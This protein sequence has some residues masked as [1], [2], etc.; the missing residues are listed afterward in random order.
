MMRAAA[1]LF[2]YSALAVSAASAQTVDKPISQMP[3]SARQLIEIK[4]TGSQRFPEADIVA[5]CGLQ[6][7]KSVGEDDF[8]RAARQLADT[9]VFGDV[10]YKYSYSASGTKVEFQVTDA[11]KFVPARFLDFVW[12]P[13]AQMRKKIKEYV[14]LFE[15]QLPLSGNM[16]NQVS[17]VLQAMLVEHAIPGHVDY[18]RGGKDNGPVESIDYKVT[19]VLIRIRKID[20]T[21]AAQPELAELESAGE[22]MGNREYSKARLQLFVQ[23][24]L[25]PVYYQRGYLKASF[26]PPQTKAVNL[27]AGEAVQ[28]GPRNQTVVDLTFAVSPGRQYKLKSLDWSGNHEFP[29]D[30]LAKM[31]HAQTGQPADLVRITDDLKQVQTLYGSHGFITAELK[32]EPQFD[33][34]AAAVTITLDVKEGFAYHMGDLQFR[35][36]DNSLTAKLRDAWQMRRGDVYNAGY[37][38][39]YLPAAQKLLPATLDWDVASHVTPNIADKTVDVD[40]IY[41]AKAPR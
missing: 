19:N 3:A 37:L 27:P 40:L 17:D 25:L 14:P 6:L 29:S 15:G 8:K 4:A 36:L 26:S 21:G 13:E 38:D 24:Q 12:F 2:L 32:P 7:G 11:D 39:Q 33:D 34:A 31:M 35:G 22:N 18:E 10:G 20:F 28:E 16:A 5:S 1:K 30:Q 41:T 9:G 23:R